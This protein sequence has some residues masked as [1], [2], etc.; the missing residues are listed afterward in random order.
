M[1]QFV[2][3]AIFCRWGLDRQRHHQQPRQIVTL[4]SSLVHSEY[5]KAVLDHG[6]RVVKDL[7]LVN[8]LVCEFPSHGGRPAGALHE[9]PEVLDLEED[10]P[11]KVLDALPAVEAWPAFRPRLR[12]VEQPPQE[13]G[14]N[15]NRIGAPEAWVI[16]K[17]QGVKV[18]VIDT[19]IA[20]N[21]PDLAENVAGQV[22]IIHP[23]RSG[24][25]DNGHGTHVAG[26]IA[27]LDNQVGVVGV[28]PR[29]RLYAV[30]AANSRGYGKV[31]D[32]IEGIDWCRENGIQVIN[33]SLGSE[34]PSRALK[35]AVEAARNCGLIIVAAAGNSARQP[36]NYPACYP[37]VLAVASTTPKDR[38][39]RFSSRG[40]GIDFAAPGERVRST[41][42]RG[43]YRTLSGTSMAAPHVTGVAALILA[44][45]CSPHE[46]HRQLFTTAESLPGLGP[47]ETGYG[48]VNAAAAVK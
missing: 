11:V 3:L 15:I 26:I 47:D 39:S 33:L 20:L 40:P 12:V 45:G 25:D 16:S 5:H 36:V 37:E 35:R 8:A 2:L 43:G 9:H 17:G 19:G 4:K 32:V 7:P 24:N 30:K 21:H 41:Y 31:S 23:M 18:G 44:G 38:L 29:A 48:L 6:G 46:V 13:I 10:F 34:R 1:Y 27:A 14:W 28:A 22:N 42:L